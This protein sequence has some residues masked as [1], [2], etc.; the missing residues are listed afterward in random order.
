MNLDEAL[1]KL[2]EASMLDPPPMADDA[3]MSGART[4]GKGRRAYRGRVYV[5][6]EDCPGWIR[7]DEEAPQEEVKPEEPA[8]SSPKGS[9][10]GDVTL[11]DPDTAELVTAVGDVVTFG[12][13]NSTMS[14]D[15][16]QY[17]RLWLKVGSMWQVSTPLTWRVVEKI[18][19]NAKKWV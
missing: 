11:R 13:G 1:R 4:L 3:A 18:S 12:D 6:H 15:N 10:R 19:E 5:R 8:K 9:D 17:G 7:T 2:E 14:N 16:D